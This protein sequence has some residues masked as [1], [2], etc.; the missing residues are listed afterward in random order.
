MYISQQ[1][2]SNKGAYYV[3][4]SEPN[5]WDATHSRDLIQVHAWYLGE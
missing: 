5:D 1:G 4:L 3:D 2:S